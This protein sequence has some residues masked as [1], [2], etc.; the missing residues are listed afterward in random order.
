MLTDPRAKELY[1]I[2]ERNDN[3]SKY[4]SH[5][6]ETFYATLNHN[7]HILSVPGAYLGPSEGRETNKLNPQIGRLV[8][9]YNQYPCL[10]GKEVRS[11]CIWGVKD[12][13][14]IL[15]PGQRHELFVN[16]FYSDF[17]PAAL[18]CLEESVRLRTLQQYLKGA[19]DFDVRFYKNLHFVKNHI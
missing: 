15:A 13:P 1:G 12:L 8:N 11:V 6:D 7:A 14:F 10:S 3:S 2:L 5:P 17:Q 16:K 18:T 4:Q 19:T 9:W